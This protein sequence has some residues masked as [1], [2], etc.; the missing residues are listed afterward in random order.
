MIE[1]LLAEAGIKEMEI[2]AYADGVLAPERRPV[3][4]AALAK[5]PE[6]MQLLESFLFT[7]GPLVE[8]YD[9]V[10]EAPI[11]EA[12]LR[13]F[14]SPPQPPAPRRGLLSFLK[15]ILFGPSAGAFRRTAL[16]LA[17]ISA[18]VLA[19]WLLNRPIGYDFARFGERGFVASPSLQRALDT[20]QRGETTGIAGGLSI[21]PRAT[22]RTVQ[23]TWCREID[24]TFPN[25]LEATALACRGG[26]GAWRVPVNLGLAAKDYGVAGGKQDK[27]QQPER[28][29]PDEGLEMLAGAKRQV[30]S[31]DATLEKEKSLIDRGWTERR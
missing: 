13:P 27:P 16:A 9:E 24:V 11:P 4:R 22:F 19:A 23:G 5:Y 8:A 3:V 10:L 12:L 20:T 7:R 1:E 26:D 15:D 6:L 25:G 18:V 30:G 14:Q 17:T 31:E 28:N 2:M 29:V 21:R